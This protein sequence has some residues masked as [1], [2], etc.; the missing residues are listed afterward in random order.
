LLSPRAS[1]SE[2]VLLHT[3]TSYFPS[4]AALRLSRSVAP[5]KH[6]WQSQFF[7][8]A[9]PIT[10]ADDE[11]YSA[12]SIL[13]EVEAAKSEKRGTKDS[14]A[15]LRGPLSDDFKTRDYFFTRLPDTAT[16]VKSIAALF[17]ADSMEAVV[18]TG[19]D[20][21]KSEL[22]E[23]DL[24]RFRF[25]HFATHGFV[26]VEPGIRESALILS[27]D[28]QDQG[29]MMLTL[30][31]IVQLKLRADMVVLSACNTGSGKVTRA[32]GVSSLG[33]A[34]LAA[35]ASSAAMSLWK[36]SDKSTSLLMQEFYRN[37]LKGMRKSEALA[38]ARSALVAQGYKNPFY[39][40][41]FVLTG[42]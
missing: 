13:P 42:E 7:G 27:Y 14:Q 20:A 21:R 29:R 9:D 28:G 19:I 41:P 35:G 4:A 31:E 17:S 15:G 25:V 40:A 38:A 39:W 6:D 32:E 1:R 33:T 34:F 3:P 18:R 24:S 23:T 30:S 10:S 5:V 22:L 2:F 37:L 16:E 36:V 12:A 11:R 8:M 26:P